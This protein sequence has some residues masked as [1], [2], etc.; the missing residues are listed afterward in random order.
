MNT[1]PE[2]RD[3]IVANVPMTLMRVLGLVFLTAPQ[4]TGSSMVEMTLRFDT[5][6]T[7]NIRK[8]VLK[9]TAPIPSSGPLALG[10]SDGLPLV[11]VTPV[12]HVIKCLLPSVT[13]LSTKSL[14]LTYALA[15]PPPRDTGRF[16]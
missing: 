15:A 8:L 3:V 9:W 12:P 11:V 16:V 10:D 6:R 7:L 1:R 2:I 5:Y 13:V 14:F 4:R